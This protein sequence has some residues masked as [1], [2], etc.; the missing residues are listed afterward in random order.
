[1]VAFSSPERV[2][3]GLGFPEGINFGP[4]GTLYC[5]DIYRGNVCIMPPRGELEVLVH[6]GGGP[7]GSRFGPDG[8]LYVADKGLRAILRVD[9]Q[10]GSWELVADG[11]E[12]RPFLGPNDL[13]FD[14]DGTLYFTDPMGSN[15]SNPIGCV[16]SL[17]PR[18]ELRRVA[19]G[20]AFPN[21]IAVTPG[22]GELL[23]A[24]TH[25]GIL[26]RYSLQQD[27]TVLEVEPL[28]KLS[29]ASDES[30]GQECG[31]DGIRFGPDGLLYVAHFGAGVVRVLTQE[32]ELVSTIPSGGPTPTNLAFWGEDLYVT[33]GT[34]GSIFRIHMLWS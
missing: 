2:A 16:Y 26:H 14:A 18:G 24:E 25:T 10:T 19:A 32:G 7:N 6:T 34:A 22:G 9:P 11:Y 29:P 23:V 1:M 33:D 8:K 28:A 12:G 3:D 21:G 30:S 4:D 5:V 20:L 13:C 15:P 31:P 17:S 27:G